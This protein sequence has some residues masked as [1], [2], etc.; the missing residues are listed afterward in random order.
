MLEQP[1]GIFDSG[2]GGLSVYQAIRQTLPHEN[3][4]F[5][6]DFAGAPWGDRSPSDINARIDYL[7][8]FL[9]QHKIKALVIACNTATALAIDRLRRRLHFPIIGIE[10]A[11]TPATRQSKSGVIGVFATTRTLQSDRYTQLKEK[12]HWDGTI[13]DIPT[14]GLADCVDQ[15]RLDTPR[16]QALI[17][18][19]WPTQSSIDQLVLG[20]THYPFLA[21]SIQKI[22]GPS[23]TLHNPA[24]AV[25][26][27]LQRQLNAHGLLRQDS[28]SGQSQFWGTGST[29]Q[30]EKI[31]CT[32]LQ[33]PTCTLRVLPPFQP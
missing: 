26:Q 5:V 30:H 18:Q 28:M 9:L 27:Q 4:L 22:V 31:L 10:P 21:K 12:I 25:A 17:R 20:C 33:D 14:P 23:V 11:I 16:V 1:I 15:G 6:A 19:Y 2:F 32:L 13:I 24:P 3:T 7:V 29:P 8:H